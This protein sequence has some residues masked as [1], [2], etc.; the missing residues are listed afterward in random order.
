[1]PSLFPRRSLK[2]DTVYQAYPFLNDANIY[3]QSRRNAF[4]LITTTAYYKL[5]HQNHVK[6]EISKV[7][8]NILQLNG[9]AAAATN[10]KSWQKFNTQIRVVVWQT[11]RRTAGTD[12]G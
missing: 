6:V 10:G 9:A 3:H 12:S 2:S 11:S 8:V 5:A 1:M 4:T 7:F